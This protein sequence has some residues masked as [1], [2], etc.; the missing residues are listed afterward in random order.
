MYEL[1][2]QEFMAHHVAHQYSPPLLEGRNES[3][4]FSLSY[5]EIHVPL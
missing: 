3:E 5:L 1:A 4:S 2:L